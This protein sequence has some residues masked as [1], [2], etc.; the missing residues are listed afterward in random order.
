MLEDVEFSNRYYEQ[1]LNEIDKA[2]AALHVVA[3]GTPDSGL[4]SDEIRNRNQVVAE[5]T[6]RTGGRRDQVLALNGAASRMK[7]LAN[8]LLHQYVVTYGRP[9]TL[10]PPEKV[11]VTVTRPGLTA[12]ARTRAAANK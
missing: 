9:E 7:Q 12:R 11:E 3:I 10:I 8:E 4:T 2:H 1:V 6:E 5:G